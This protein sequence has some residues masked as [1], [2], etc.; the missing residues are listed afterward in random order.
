[1]QPLNSDRSPDRPARDFASVYRDHHGFVWRTL[2]HLGVEPGRVDDAAQDTFLVVHRRLGEFEGRAALSTWLFEIARRVAARYRRTAAREASRQDALIETAGAWR[3]DEQLERA[4]AAEILRRFL[5]E[6]DGDKSVVFVLA[7]LEQWQV[8]EIAEALELNVNTVHARLRAARIQLE[9]L[10][11][12]LRAREQRRRFGSATEVLAAVAI[13]IAPI[14]PPPIVPP[15]TGSVAGDPEWIVRVGEGLA[16]SVAKV[17]TIGAVSAPTGVGVLVTGVA[18]AAV[19]ASAGTEAGPPARAEVE[20][21][22]V[23]PVA[24]PRPASVAA[25]AVE[26]S[27][28][29]QREEAAK[30]AVQSMAPGRRARAESTGDLAAELATIEAARAALLAGDPAEALA[31]LAEHA[32]RFPRGALVEEAAAAQIEALCQSGARARARGEAEAFARRWPGSSLAAR[33]G[34]LCPP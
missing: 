17:A 13:P 30:V 25:P 2:R 21:A 5:E 7:E 24:E 28:G 4:E 22:I 26:A 3:L 16:G 6:L 20:T 12:R 31:R 34:A 8:T 19:L 1:M 29:P 11:R 15:P 9:R 18:L 23:R 33:V 32:R 14:V 27:V 10:V